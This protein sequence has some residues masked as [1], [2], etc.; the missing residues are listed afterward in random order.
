MI[1]PSWIRGA[2]HAAA[3]A[4]LSSPERASDDRDRLRQ[5]D[6]S[7]ARAPASASAPLYAAHPVGDARSRPH[8][9]AARHA[10]GGARVRAE[11]RRL[12]R[13]AARA[14]AAKRR[15][16]PT[17]SWC[18]CA[19][20][21]TGSRIVAACAARSGPKRTPTASGC[22]CVAGNAPHIDRRIGDFLRREAKR[23]LEAASLRFAG[24]LGCRVKRVSRARSIEPLGLMLDDRRA[25]VFLAAHSGAG[26]VLDYLAAHEVAH[27]VEMNHS[28]RFWRLVQRLCPG[29]RTRQGV[30]RRARRGSAPLRLAR[31][32]SRTGLRRR[33]SFSSGVA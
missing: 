25:V 27:L 24:E 2:R 29:S 26:H 7:G 28:A 3:C 21:R 22:L 8:H 30:A 12:D 31:C 5:I 16:S 1:P 10:E 33:D 15:R 14:A 18:R 11:A 20:C 32:Q 4:A 17:A 23:D 9:S 13:G 19:A 6:L